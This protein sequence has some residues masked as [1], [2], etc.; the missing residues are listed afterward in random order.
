MF[1]LMLNCVHF[2]GKL[3]NYKN[4][5]DQFLFT[6]CFITATNSLIDRFQVCRPPPPYSIAP[7]L[8]FPNKE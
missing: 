3:C 5:Q 6:V 4:I 7:V 2:G 1:A 8:T